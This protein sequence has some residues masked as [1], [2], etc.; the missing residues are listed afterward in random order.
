MTTDKRP[1]RIYNEELKS[2]ALADVVLLGSSATASKYGIPR[3]TLMTWQ[4]QFN[5]VH[6]P[7]LKRDHIGALVAAYL[8]ANLQALTSQ[9]YVVSQPEYIERQP[10]EGVAILHGVMADKSIR[11]LEAISRSQPDQPA[12]DSE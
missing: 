6:N 8:E 5:I 7:A 10:A 4:Q 12:L 3:S 1:H 9:A 11:L 2:A